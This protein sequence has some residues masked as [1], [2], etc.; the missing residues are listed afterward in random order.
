MAHQNLVFQ[1]SA[2]MG[3]SWERT[4]LHDKKTFTLHTL[5]SV[6]HKL[7]YSN[8]DIIVLILLCNIRLI[9]FNSMLL[10]DIMKI[11]R[12]FLPLK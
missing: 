11:F 6:L 10:P 2:Q 3:I 1:S 12:C 8:I 4:E 5:T 9:D 7:Y